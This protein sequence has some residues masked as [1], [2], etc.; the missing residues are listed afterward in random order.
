VLY[1]YKLYASSLP[2]PPPVEG[3]KVK[4][5][6]TQDEYNV[7]IGE[8]KG[9]DTVVVIDFYATWC[10]PCRACAPAYA[11]LSKSLCA[12]EKKCQFWKVDVD[13]MQSLA[14]SLGVSSMPTFKIF[15]GTKE[16]EEL[17]G[18]N[19]SRLASAVTRHMTPGAEPSKKQ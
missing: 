1:I 13:K 4:T 7:A 9:T 10:P 3:S 16:V 18:W 11:L 6:N 15:I 19:E 14:R 5:L 8:V 2:E 17:K 12:D